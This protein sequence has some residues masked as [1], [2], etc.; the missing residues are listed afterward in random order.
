[1]PRIVRHPF[2][3]VHR[4]AFDDPEAL[5]RAF[6]FIG[7]AIALAYLIFAPAL[8][9]HAFDVGELQFGVVT[10]LRLAVITV[11]YHAAF[12]VLGY[13]QPITKSLILSSYLNGVYFPIYMTATLP[14]FLVFGPQAYFEPLSA[15]VA[16]DDASLTELAAVLS[17]YLLVLVAYPL[18]L[19]VASYW[20]AKAFNAR[21]W[22]STALLLVAI[23]LAGLA[24]FYVLPMATRLF[25]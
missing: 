23:A 19:A 11:L 9:R 16:R 18:C 24:N 15:G 5:K 1:M 17:G 25:L 2:G 3:F 7:A 22:L 20:W 6:K 13:R 4:I 21:V 14:G 10:L 12:F 8:T